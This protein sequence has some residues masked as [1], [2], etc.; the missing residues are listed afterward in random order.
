MPATGGVGKYLTRWN[1]PAFI[2][3]G[4]R[5]ESGGYADGYHVDHNDLNAVTA[6][7]RHEPEVQIYE[8]LLD[9]TQLQALATELAKN[10][11]A[12]RQRK[13][14][15]AKS[16]GLLAHLQSVVGFEGASDEAE[17]TAPELPRLKTIYVVNVGQPSPH[18]AGVSA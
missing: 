18:I 13:M 3:G 16:S 8:D 2:T 4:V 12:E 15:I 10:M 6:E 9:E 7:L 14:D 11:F 5:P 17:C 1:A